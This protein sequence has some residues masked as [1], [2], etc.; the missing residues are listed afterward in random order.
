VKAPMLNVT[1]PMPVL[2]VTFENFPDS[3]V[4]GEVLTGIMRI[5]NNGNRGL[6]NLRLKVS[7]PSFFYAGSVLDQPVYGIFLA[8]LY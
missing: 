7:H 2:D 4:S 1:L 8:Y 3:M 5:K 6:R